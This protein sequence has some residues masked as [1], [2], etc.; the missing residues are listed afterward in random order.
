MVTRTEEREIGAVSG[1]LPDNLGE[2]VCMSF[3]HWINS[4]VYIVYYQKLIRGW[5]V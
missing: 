1:T 5:N 3:T 4:V 2:L